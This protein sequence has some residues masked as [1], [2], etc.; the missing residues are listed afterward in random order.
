[1]KETFISSQK[2]PCFPAFSITAQ[3][4]LSALAPENIFLKKFSNTRNSSVLLN[5]DL[6]ECLDCK[7]DQENGVQLLNQLIFVLYRALHSFLLTAGLNVYY[8]RTT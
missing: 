8:H 6:E 1:M 4:F 5:I 3:A 2:Q 7:M